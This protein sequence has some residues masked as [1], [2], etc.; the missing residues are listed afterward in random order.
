M[1]NLPFESHAVSYLVCFY[2]TD[3]IFH[4]SGVGSGREDR[5]VWK[6]AKD[7]NSGCAQ[8]TDLV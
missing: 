7:V 5:E 2:D 6:D 3:M 8:I 4:L 1:H